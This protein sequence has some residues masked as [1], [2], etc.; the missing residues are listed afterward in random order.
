MP[1][2]IY[3]VPTDKVTG[4]WSQVGG[5]VNAVYPLTNIDEESPWNPTVFTTNPTRIVC[6]HGG[7]GARIE[8]LAFINCNFPAGLSVHARRG[9]VLGTATQDVSVTCPGPTAS[10]HTSNPHADLS[11]ANVGTYR[12]TW[13]DLG[14]SVPLLSLGLIR[15]VGTKRSVAR[16]INWRP[17]GTKKFPNIER[18][19]DADTQ[20]G[21][22]RG[23]RMRGWSTTIQPTDAG[24]AALDAAYEACL[25]RHRPFLFIIDPNVNE[26]MWVKWGTN[27][28]W[29][30]SQSHDFLDL[31]SLVI[32]VD[33]LGRGLRP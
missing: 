2:L 8:Y 12:Y 33:E 32:D 17:K 9:N 25:G 19:T 3:D 26:A 4:T 5:A 29:V 22:S 21:Y 31:H 10:G 13:Y 28:E 11:G 6:D 24:F 27:A 18:A 16:N 20:L 15:Q 1:N 7:G 30:F 23:T 14:A